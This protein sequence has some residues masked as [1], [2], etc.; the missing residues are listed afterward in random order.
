MGLWSAKVRPEHC[1]LALRLARLAPTHP[2]PLTG[3]ASAGS[4]A[5][6]TAF[7]R[8]NNPP[9]ATTGTTLGPRYTGTDV[10]VVN[11]RRD[12]DVP[13]NMR[14]KS[15]PLD[16][17]RLPLPAYQD[18]GSDASFGENTLGR[19]RGKF[20]NTAELPVEARR[21]RAGRLV[22]EGKCPLLRPD[23]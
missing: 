2:P 11:R 16:E 7:T 4:V 17:S 18:G 13:V 9:K 8:G 19:R 12:T 10:D 21:Q 14:L 23:Y 5:A 3:R 22:N 1:S 15:P 6:R 20:S